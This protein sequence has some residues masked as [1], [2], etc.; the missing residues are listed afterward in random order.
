MASQKRCVN[1]VFQTAT[2]QRRKSPR[3]AVD[4]AFGAAY[5]RHVS[6]SFI[7]RIKIIKMNARLENAQE[8]LELMLTRIDKAVARQESNPDTAGKLEIL[9]AEHAALRDRH[10]L[11][12]SRLD[13]A[14]SR[15]QRV[16]KD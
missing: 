7:L 11:I 6:L 10:Q 9:T 14:I 13:A 12:S 8:Q 15:L 16:L 1:D 3:G 5:G 4:D 2:R